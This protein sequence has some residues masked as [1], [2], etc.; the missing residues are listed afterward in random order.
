[1]SNVTM[2]NVKIAADDILKYFSYF[3]QKIGFDISCKLSPNVKACFLG[4]V[5]KTLS[6]CHLL[7]QPREQKKLILTKYVIAIFFLISSQ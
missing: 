2:F 4:K 5:R 7:N 6:F 3:S 1:M